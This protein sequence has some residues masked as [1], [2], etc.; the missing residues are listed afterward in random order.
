MAGYIYY[1][2]ATS[3]PS[4]LVSKTHGQRT[5][6]APRIE[7]AFRNRFQVQLAHMRFCRAPGFGGYYAIA[8]SATMTTEPA[9]AAATSGR[10]LI[11]RAA[12]KP[13]GHLLRSTRQQSGEKFGAH[14]GFQPDD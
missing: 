4:V 1:E 11:G 2:W 3:G 6:V 9:T 8:A 14:F 5:L 7:S 12:N 10:M 13:G